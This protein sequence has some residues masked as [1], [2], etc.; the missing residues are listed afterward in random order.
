MIASSAAKDIFGFPYWTTSM[1]ATFVTL[2]WPAAMLAG[3]RFFGGLESGTIDVGF[4]PEVFD[5]HLNRFRY[6]IHLVPI[7]VSIG[8]APSA[9]AKRPWFV[10]LVSAGIA[11]SVLIVTLVLLEWAILIP[12]SPGVPVIHRPFGVQ[13]C[14]IALATGFAATL[15]CV[16]FVLV[17]SHA[18]ETHLITTAIL[19]TLMLR[20]GSAWYVAV[21]AGILGIV[22]GKWFSAPRDLMNPFVVF[23]ILG[24][25]SITI[26]K[27]IASL[28]LGFAARLHGLNVS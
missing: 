16:T 21:V 4:G 13:G 7:Y 3:Q 2:Y 18:A 23:L 8:F 28:V 9:R 17:A 12:G 5:L 22:T 24:E 27:P 1:L 11:L 19:V 15:L 6:R 10:P 14:L 25:M 26:T 20:N